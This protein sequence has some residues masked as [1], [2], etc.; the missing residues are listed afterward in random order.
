MTKVL[1]VTDTP[2]IPTSYANCARFFA[3]AVAPLGVEVAF[4]SIQH[5]GERLT[6]E[7]NGRGYRHYG[8]N[9]PYRIRAAVEDFDPDVVLHL[10]D[11]VPLI[12][13]YFPNGNYTVKGQAGGRPTWH[14]V[15]V[16]HETLPW[17][18][19]D[20]LHREADVVLPFT[21]VGGEALGNAGLV[22]DR[23]EPLPLGVSP[24][25]SDPEGPVA[26]GYGRPGIP[27]VMSVGL[28]HQDRKAFP[29]LMRAYREVIGEIDLE[30]YIHSMEVAAFDLLEHIKMLGVDGHW[31]FPHL[32]DPQFGYPEEEFATRYR[33]ATA[34]AS[35]G[36]GEGWDMPLSEAA[37]LGRV[38]FV[39]ND[40]NRLEVVSDYEGPKLVFDTFPIPRSMNWE[41]LPDPHSLAQQ[42]LKLKDLK[43]DPAAGRR[44]FEKHTWK[45]T[46]EQFV[47]VL[48]SRGIP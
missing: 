47:K 46:A 3:D 21:V 20:A 38:M 44:Y 13:K 42:L 25:Y 10:R 28:G 14:W 34:Y 16:Q 11:P 26:T 29:V 1:L 40:P 9:P 17:D 19:I 41:R 22:R 35:V 45:K 18:Y 24:S 27:L 7:F 43:P 2:A 15:P 12:P 4:G 39:P 37:A 31:M 32:Y 48:Q 23:I 36:T 30:F 5:M 6:Y 33:R 8:C